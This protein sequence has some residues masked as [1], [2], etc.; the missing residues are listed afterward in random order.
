MSSV[1]GSYSFVFLVGSHDSFTLIVQVITFPGQQEKCFHCGQ[2]GHL[3]AECHGKPG[4]NAANGNGVDD[5]PIHKKKYQ[6][7]ELASWFWFLKFELFP[8]LFLCLFLF[9]DL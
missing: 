5:T 2:A 6:V 4:D 7:G 3:A 8:F 1:L 9:T